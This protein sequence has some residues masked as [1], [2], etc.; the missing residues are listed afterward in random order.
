MKGG[1]GAVFVSDLFFDPAFGTHV[2]NV[3]VPI[4]DDEQHVAIGAITILLRRDTLFHRYRKHGGANG[5]R[6]VIQFRRRSIDL[7][8]SVS[9]RTCGHA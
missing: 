7:S 8:G 1:I 2:L 9:R 4:L 5:P 6:N 3:S